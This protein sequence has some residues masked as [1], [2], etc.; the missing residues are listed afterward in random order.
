MANLMT[1]PGTGLGFGDVATS[2]LLRFGR[3]EVSIA[4]DCRTRYFRAHPLIECN[5]GVAPGH[6]EILVLRRWRLVLS[7]AR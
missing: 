3:R 1:S 2:I 6:L 7:K 5:P 4:R